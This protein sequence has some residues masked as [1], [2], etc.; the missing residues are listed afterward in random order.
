MRSTI[1]RGIVQWRVKVV[2]PFVP[3]ALFEKKNLIMP[4]DLLLR[5]MP[6][7]LEDVFDLIV[8]IDAEQ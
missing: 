4:K 3:Q 6:M 1:P 5:S 8:H 7:E 2:K